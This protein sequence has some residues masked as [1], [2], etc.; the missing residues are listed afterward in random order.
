MCELWY[1][2]KGISIEFFSILSEKKK[3]RNFCYEVDCIFD[4]KF[5]LHSLQSCLINEN[6]LRANLL[7]K[8]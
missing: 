6:F 1:E 8:K 2:T 5:F 3:A 7:M 4:V